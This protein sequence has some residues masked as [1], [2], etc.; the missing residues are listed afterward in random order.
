MTKN[1]PP[2][3]SISQPAISASIEPIITTGNYFAAHRQLWIAE[4]LYVYGFLNRVH[5]RRKFGISI[6]QASNDL[7]TFMKNN[8]SI[9]LLYDHKSR[10][11]RLDFDKLEKIDRQQWGVPRKPPP[12]LHYIPRPG[13]NGVA[14]S[15][16][17]G[18]E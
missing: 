2:E 9:P 11:Y 10:I 13:T 14:Y 8:P 7:S 6:P 18:R 5:L 17:T 1:E 12:K 15:R 16:P 4:S 3:G